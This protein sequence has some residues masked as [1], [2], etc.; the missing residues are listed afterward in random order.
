MPIKTRPQNM[1]GI[2]KIE[3]QPFTQAKK[4]CPHSKP[5][6]LPLTLP[7]LCD[8]RAFAVKKPLPLPILNIL[9]NTGS[10][11]TAAELLRK[12]ATP[13]AA[14]SLFIFNTKIQIARAVFCCQNLFQYHRQLRMI[15]EY[16]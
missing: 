14:I 5:L 1:P 16:L 12:T 15:L 7:Y 11:K 3:T 8:L 10:Q 4:L 6:P 2:T 9:I 13:V